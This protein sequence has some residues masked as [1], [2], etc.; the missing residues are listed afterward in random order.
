MGRNGAGKTTVLRY[1]LGLARLSA[2]QTWLDGRPR[3]DP[4]AMRQRRK[5]RVDSVPTCHA[6]RIG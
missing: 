2:G 5:A 6:G 3:P 1:I 4:A